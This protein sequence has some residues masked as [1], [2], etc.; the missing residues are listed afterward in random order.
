M[1]KV[2]IIDDEE[3]VRWG[4]H[5]LLDWESEG[6]V[7][8]EDGR[9]GKDG[10]RKLLETCPDLVLVDI[11]MPGLSGIELIQAARSEG[12]N[13]HFII[14][15]G[16]AEFEF[17]KSAVS[18]GVREYLL[19]PIDEEELG[20]CVR[21]IREELEKTD[22]ERLYHSTNEDI[23]REEL[24]RKIIFQMDVREKLEEQLKRYEISFEEHIWCTAILTDRDLLQHRETVSF[25]QKVHFFL[26]DK[27]LYEEKLTADSQ[28]VLIHRG[29]DYKRWVE[30]LSK[31]NERLKK[32]FGDSLLITVGYNVS[33]WYDL[34]YSYE[35][36]YF[37]LEKEFLFG[38]YDVLSVSTIEEQ[39]NIAE[40]PSPEHIIMLIEVG[41]LDGIRGCVEK[42]RLYCIREL[43]KEMD[44]KIQIMYNLM[45][46]RNG[47]E[48]KY[49]NLTEGITQLMEELNRAEK[50]DW[51]MELY[52]QILQ[53][54]CRQIG[55]DG[56]GTVI[57]RMYY[58]MEKN[59]GQDLKLESFA[60]M[61]G[62]N[63]NYLGKIFRKEIGDSFNNI[64]D[65]IRITNAKRL[66]E[67]TN[68]KVYQ[69]SEQVGYS[70]IDYFYLKFKKYVGISPK[71]YKKKREI[72]SEGYT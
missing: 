53:D 34:C 63:S 21:K 36:A 33:K 66:L 9:D 55:N 20:R 57:K 54:M 40:N 67:E 4:I 26:E 46:I 59:Y 30:L 65:A 39:Q 31:R 38:A 51:L 17:A 19:K 62:Y 22:G 6:F 2:M 8:L 18:L 58:Y 69:I 47:I 11:K 37:L 24:F 14:L 52:C 12:Y 1:Y 56:S 13:G 42:F 5:D 48:K 60:K 44:I 35:F 16:Y 7:F 61:F 27:S 10:L 3:M 49:G 71:E 45:L 28:F 72:V 50:L 43:M 29:I 15:T 23:A 64:L 68:L 70:N 41:D 25:Q 32:R